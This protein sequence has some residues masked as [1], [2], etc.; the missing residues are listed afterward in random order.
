LDIIPPVLIFSAEIMNVANGNYKVIRTLYSFTALAMWLRFLY[1]FRIYR[2]T[3]F[4]IRMII[5]VIKDMGQFFFI[6]LVSV[7]AFG[8][9][10]FIFGL[11]QEGIEND[12]STL[13]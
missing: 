4:Y 9:C 10:F 6:F 5:E 8:H 1:F 3:N 12:G 2:N 13:P 11:N 7:L